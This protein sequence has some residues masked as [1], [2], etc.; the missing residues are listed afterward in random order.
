MIVG[1]ESTEI[2]GVEDIEEVVAEETEEE[3]VEDVGENA[4]DISTWLSISAPSSSTSS[5]FGN[6]ESLPPTSDA[7]MDFELGEEADGHMQEWLTLKRKQ[8]NEPGVEPKSRWK[9]A[10]RDTGSRGGIT[11]GVN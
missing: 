10:R 5:I 1:T 4:E 11:Q 6:R 3:E 7:S 8:H 2:E 9:V